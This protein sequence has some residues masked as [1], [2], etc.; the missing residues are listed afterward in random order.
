MRKEKIL[1][2]LLVFVAF[3]YLLILQT[4]AIW[5]FTIDDMYITLRYA[6]NWVNDGALL[7]N[8]GEAPVEGYSNFSFV[9]IAALALHCGL[10][11]VLVL[12]GLGVISLVLT[13]LALYL[14]SRLWLR[15]W[16]ALIPC[17]WMLLYS[18]QI[19]WSVSGL[20]TTTYQAFL[21]FG[22]FCLLRAIGYRPVQQRRVL[23]T[24]DSIVFRNRMALFSG[25]LV[26]FASLTRPEA[27]ILAALFYGIALCDSRGKLDFRYLYPIF[28]SIIVFAVIYLPYFF[29]R[30]HY[31]GYLFPNPVY[32][33]GINSSAIGTLDKGFIALAWPFIILALPVIFN[34]KDK[35]PFY[36]CLPALL[37]CI[38][39][40]SADPIVAFANRLFLPAFIL[41]LPLSLSGMGWIVEKFLAQSDKLYPW[42]LTMTACWVALFCIP[43]MSLSDLR[44]FAVNPVQGERMR[45]A[46]VT[47]L[48]RYAA[49][50]SDV[51]LGDSGIIPYLSPLR[52]IDSYC[53]NNKRMI[54]LPEA[55]RYDL[56]CSEILREKPKVI[57]L[58]SLYDNKKNIYTPVDNCLHQKLKENKG[59]QLRISFRSGGNHRFYRYEIYTPI[60]SI[61][62]NLS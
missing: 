60:E 34:A 56:Y 4:Q 38:L 55:K 47:W 11:P 2:A 49:A 53:L 19:L 26:A 9:L 8:S 58:T 48:N 42:A 57:I 27:P 44:F 6:R 31:Y 28:L 10:N 7:W 17:L 33:K 59:Y 12:K 25:L 54:Q 29:W 13:T 32:C 35:R 15:A 50:D 30:W 1:L 18:G 37:Y 41:L 43:K 46:V 45:V 16:L 61:G 23:T 21:S 3:V 24:T 52:F 40:V 62:S 20:E 39:L 5:P 36:F 22:L 14:L 51:L